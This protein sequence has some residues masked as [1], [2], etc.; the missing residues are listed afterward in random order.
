[1]IGRRAAALLALAAFSGEFAMADGKEF[2]GQATLKIYSG[3]PDPSWPL[4]ETQAAALLKLVDAL[5]AQA[6]A[7]PPPESWATA[8]FRR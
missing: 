6:S 5:P 2:S 8:V 4:G 1:M 3:R 7:P